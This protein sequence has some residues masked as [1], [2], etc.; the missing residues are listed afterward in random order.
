M[1]ASTFSSVA[2]S[3][4]PPAAGL[5]G[6]RERGRRPRG[7]A[8][9]AGGVCRPLRENRPTLARHTMT[10]PASPRSAYRGMR[11]RGALAAR[12]RRRGSG[13]SGGVAREREARV[14]LLVGACQCARSSSS[15][16]SGAAR[17]RRSDHAER[18]TPT[19]H[20]RLL[21]PARD[22]EARG[23][24]LQAGQLGCLRPRTRAHPTV[25]PPGDPTARCAQQLIDGID[26]PID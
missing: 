23:M 6:A 7:A 15:H 16:R 14:G 9:R 3:P 22:R 1:S 2:A 20:R 19:A 17:T 26:L 8:Q 13:R 24:R 18:P 12:P 5:V 10:A 4:A 21:R 25:R 11:L